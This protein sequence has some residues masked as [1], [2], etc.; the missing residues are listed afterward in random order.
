MAA[1]HHHLATLD[2]G[3]FTE[4][5]KPPMTQSKRD[6]IDISMDSVERF[7]QDWQGGEVVAGNGEVAPFM[8]CLGSH[9]YQVYMHW[10]KENGVTRYRERNQFIGTLAKLRGWQAGKSVYG[11]ES[12]LPGAGPKNRKMV[13]PAN[14]DIKRSPAGCVK[15]SSGA[16]VEEFWLQ[17]G[18]DK[19]IW[20]TRSF[21][22][23]CNATGIAP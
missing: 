19:V 3:D 8:P 9:L 6:V 17:D 12:L 14:E 10:C 22:G 7:V 23:F 5:S 21:F 2:L 16:N 4:H 1:L 13:I 11:R 15:G 18:E 20:L